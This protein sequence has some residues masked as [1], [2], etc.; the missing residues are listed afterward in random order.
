MEAIVLSNFELCS[1]LDMISEITGYTDFRKSPQLLDSVPLILC[2]LQLASAPAKRSA[3]GILGRSNLVLSQ[4]TSPSTSR[5]DPR[6][7]L[8]VFCADTWL[9]ALTFALVPELSSTG[10]NAVVKTWQL[11]QEAHMYQNHADNCAS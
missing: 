11:S 5:S 3:S 2:I 10:A 9:A 8:V 7:Q 1:R 6:A 4:S